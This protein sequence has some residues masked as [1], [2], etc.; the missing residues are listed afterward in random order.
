MSAA[1]GCWVKIHFC[2]NESSEIAQWDVACDL[3]DFEWSDAFAKV[4]L[5]ACSGS[6][7]QQ[8]ESSIRQ[9]IST[10]LS[11]GSKHARM[12][13]LPPTA[14]GNALPTPLEVV[15]EGLNVRKNTCFFFFSN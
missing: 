14:A 12:Y 7:T 15:D 11:K 2:C 4:R 6:I 8:F 9:K 5:L 3:Q 10:M 13:V 1:G